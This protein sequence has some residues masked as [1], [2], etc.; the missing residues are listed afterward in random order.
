ML[1]NSSSQNSIKRQ[2]QESINKDNMTE[3]SA[4]TDEPSQ[5]TVAIIV[6]I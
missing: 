4:F 6:F 3:K 1:Q 5:G 2:Q